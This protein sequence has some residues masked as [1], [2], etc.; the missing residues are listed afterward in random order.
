MDYIRFAITNPV[1]VSVAV[2]LL[3]LFG[4]IAL[5]TIPI[6]LVPNVDQPVIN[7]TTNWTG[8]SPEEVEREIIEEQEDKL[9]GVTNLKK[10]T[11]TASQG[12]AKIELEF[13]IGTDMTR[14]LQEVSDKL[15]EVPSY[16][17]DVDQPVVAVADS[18][19]ENAIA[20]MILDCED[21][22]FDVASLYDFADKRI[23]P[24]LERIKGVAEVNIYGGREREVHIRV[25]PLRMAERQI[26]FNQLRDALRLENVNIS[27][28]EM[29]E[30][31][32]DVRVRTVG[33]YEDTREVENTIIAY[34]SAEGGP[35]RVRDI[36]DV[37]LTLEKK[38][39][40]VRTKG[41]NAIAINA[42][43]ES[44]S[45][46]V[47]VMRELRQRVAEINRDILP[48]ARPDLHFTQVYDET[49][50]IDDALQLVLDNLWQGGILTVLVL[51]VFLR[52]FRSPWVVSIAAGVLVFC[53]GLALASDGTLRV[54]ALVGIAISM[55]VVLFDSPPTAIIAVA[56]PLSIVGTFVVMTAFG[57]NLNVISLAGL[58]F[59]VGMVVDNAIV[60]L[61]NID[62]H[63][64]MGKTAFKAAYD[65]TTEV[66]TAIIASTATTLVVFLPV[67]TIKEE[68]GQLFL[69][70]S[71]AVCA[72]VALSLM[73]AVTV[74]PTA[75]SRWLHRKTPATTP[76][77]RLFEDAFGL[78]TIL[79]SITEDVADFVHYVNRRP[80]FG[81]GIR[82]MVTLAGLWLIAAGILVLGFYA[83]RSDK[84]GET[85]TL[86][87]ADIADSLTQFVGIGLIFVG[88]VGM[89]LLAFRSLVKQQGP[90][91][92]KTIFFAVA[93]VLLVLLGSLTFAF[94]DAPS[95]G[96]VLGHFVKQWSVVL[97]FIVI[98]IGL[99]ML[100]GRLRVVGVLTFVSLLSSWLLMPPTTYLP[101][102][103]RNLVFGIML[104][105]PGYNLE[106]N[107][108]IAQR[109]E[110]GVRPY[111][112]AMTNAESAL[113]PPT[114][115]FVTGKVMAVPPI[116]NFFFVSFGSN[117]FMGAASRD[118]NNVAPL[119]PLISTSMSSIPGAFGFAQQVSLFGRG[120]AGTNAVDIEIS[121]DDLDSVRSAANALY[122]ALTS[123]PNYGF[124]NVRPDPLNFNLTGPELQI[125]IDRVRA[126]DLGIDNA[127]LGLGVQALVDGVII[128]DYR[129]G[130]D[131]I[132]LLMTRSPDYPLTRETLAQVPVAVSPLLGGGTVM[133]SDVAT[134][135]NTTAPQQIKR[136]EQ[137]RAIS[138]SVMPPA[139]VPLEQA[140]AEIA[141]VVA[142]LR[143]SGKIGKDIESRF[144]G[145]ADKLVQVREALVGQWYGL[146]SM[147]NA[148]NSLRSIVFSRLFLALVVNYLVMAWLFNSFL[149]PFVI[150]F[151]VPLAMVGGFL[152]LR[153]VHTFDP[154]QL[155]DVV[156]MLGFVILLGTVVNNAILIVSQSLNFMRGFG[157]SEQDKLE[158]AM[159]PKE[160][161]R[162]AVR[163]RLRPVMMTTITTLCGMLPLV[164]KPGAGS[165]LYKGLGGV[166]LGGLL[167]S[168]IFT[169]IVVPSVF[170]L[171]LDVKFAIYRRLGWP[172]PELNEVEQLQ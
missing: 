73:V 39:S 135:V 103:N 51:L 169:L 113:L 149:Y 18:A 87:K 81:S 125:K 55:A 71:L 152:G 47:E 88:F 107:E 128:G 132:D 92:G 34:N 156:T 62:R 124:M 37:K 114:V 50:Y 136:I 82:F 160:A 155:L 32:L 19:S 2:I 89:G 148:I 66:F 38:R 117:I 22:D 96:Q 21:P 134:L 150:L 168:T 23:K 7:I 104:T 99:L 118:K 4:L 48:V 100:P 70:I 40:F 29:A 46:V 83:G 17:A 140:T 12:Q 13:Y 64:G 30:G 130:G 56:I 11:A 24:Y 94:P 45:N 95:T 25:N 153:V 151:S 154:S 43:R 167:V 53:G 1:K 84:L 75:G 106:Q 28:G 36:A 93:G 33:Q 77:R 163:T 59:A 52:T 57:R 129:L 137:R 119:G 15:R 172:I 72:A 5:F 78:A 123:N 165:E 76:G 49:I 9:K 63:L 42:I 142:G 58:A 159:A 127:T 138:F 60:V 65:A 90:W 133:L 105:P 131:S 74:I 10:M 120:L 101:K 35:I 161:I 8:R 61:E 166:V 3:L 146:D 141:Q 147:D 110:V 158:K 144:A 102:G 139:T 14:G 69:D 79:G 68:A 109:V 91:L 111:W 31:R 108:F 80:L 26:T 171:T 41:K 97:C 20:W 157:E 85:L 121:G 170:S 67:L 115:D 6:Q 145:T 27:A 54:V 16:P 86:F 164:V 116:E 98:V 122:M 126:A 162:E 143:K 44:G 112:E